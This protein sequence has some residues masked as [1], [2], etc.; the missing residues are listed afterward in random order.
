VNVHDLWIIGVIHLIGG[1]RAVG[2]VI[3]AGPDLTGAGVAL[4]AP[5]N[6]IFGA[7]I[8]RG[9]IYQIRDTLAL[10]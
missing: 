5:V 6:A 4:S 8:V 3:P 1:S 2:G 10:I 9:G 7:A